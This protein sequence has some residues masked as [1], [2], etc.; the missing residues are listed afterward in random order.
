MRHY[1]DHCPLIGVFNSYERIVHRAPKFLQFLAL[2][3][4]FLDHQAPSKHRSVVGR[5]CFYHQHSYALGSA[6]NRYLKS[7]LV[8]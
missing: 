5:R 8:R 2:K 6:V 1:R 7:G 3:Y 4:H